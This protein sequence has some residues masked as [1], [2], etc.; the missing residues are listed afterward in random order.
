MT[1]WLRRRAARRAAMGC[2]EA[3]RE[4]QAYLDGETDALT[5]ARLAAHLEHCRWCGLELA[6]YREIKRALARRR[7]ADP[8]AVRRLRDYGASLAGGAEGGGPENGDRG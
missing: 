1:G 8:R 2:A 7:A 6:T 3:L 5:A 4:L